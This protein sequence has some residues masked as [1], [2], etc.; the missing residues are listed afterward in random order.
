V[1]E[2]HDAA[3]S[4][5]AVCGCSNEQTVGTT[6]EHARALRLAPADPDRGGTPRACVVAV[7]W[8]SC[9]WLLGNKKNRHEI[10]LR[11]T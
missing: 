4:S 10:N 5:S 8:F 7:V 6:V 2:K 11:S 9:P 1:F 3:A